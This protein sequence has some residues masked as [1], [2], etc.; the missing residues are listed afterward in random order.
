MSEEEALEAILALVHRRTGLDLRGYRRTTMRRRVA[1]R[2]A[3]ARVESLGRYRELLEASSDETLPLL[4]SLLVKVSRFYRN[5]PAFDLVR[6]EVLPE[7]ATLA[8]G[9]ALR[10]WSA[11]CGR[12]EE[13][14]TL[15]M[16]LEDR[17]IEGTVTATDVDPTAL[18]EAAAGIYPESAL[19][20][21]PRELRARHLESFDAKRG[22]WKVR[23]AVRARI[24]WHQD[25]L[26][27]PS[28]PPAEYDLVACRN[29]LIYLDRAAQARV[30]ARLL[31]S[32]AP[33]G[34]LF[35]GEAEWVP[36]E[37]S[38]ALAPVW[39]RWRLF[40]ALPSSQRLAA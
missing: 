17:G 8:R 29:V 33:G 30:L 40:R 16:L 7:L 39:P 13:A 26:S 14:Y 2:M 11:G 3:C 35:L 19:Q 34:Y 25:D 6:R 10:I 27:R 23:D 1:N 4:Q 24:Q 21:L 18:A 5:A 9:P 28:A 31:A 20:E 38:S 32:V 36:P 37:Q 15:A 22:A 12:G